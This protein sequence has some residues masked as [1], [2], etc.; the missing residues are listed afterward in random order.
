MNAGADHAKVAILIVEDEPSLAE[1]MRTVVDDV[2]GWSATVAHDAVA[3][4][5]L[6]QQVK[7]EVLVLDIN[8]PGITGL[9]L[10]E[11][12]RTDETW[13]DQPII[14]VSAVADQDRWQAPLQHARPSAI[15]SKPFELDELTAAI[16]AVLRS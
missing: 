16:G 11:L 8:L 10:L 5:A 7:I 2:D 15:L 1:L 13:A 6:F 4:R 14:V 3:A 12:L 9:E